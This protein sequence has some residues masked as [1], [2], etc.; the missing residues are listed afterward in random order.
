MKEIP[1]AENYLRKRY[2]IQ[3]VS[4][5]SDNVEALIEFAK[6]HADKFREQM[7][8]YDSDELYQLYL[9]NAYPSTEIK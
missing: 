2:D 7:K 8:L 3:G 1:S 4:S 5:F 9:K 6:L